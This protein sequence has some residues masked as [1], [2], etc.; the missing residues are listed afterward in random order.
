M[1]TMTNFHGI[2]PAI[3][4]PFR[5]DYGID[6]PELRRFAAW[7]G[8]R[9]GVIGLMT[10]GHTGE[11]FSHTP[12]ERATV[13]RIVADELRGRLPVISSI[14]CEGFADAAEH[15][16]MADVRPRQ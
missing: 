6:E 8:R 1:R 16:R 9:K 12:T 4:V 7:L 3:A 11:V 15:G 13:T 10:N 14:V 5:P 2:I